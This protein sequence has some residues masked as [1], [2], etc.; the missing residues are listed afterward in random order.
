MLGFVKRLLEP[1]KWVVIQQ[2]EIRRNVDNTVV[3]LLYV[4]QDQYGR[5]KKKRICL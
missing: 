4:M 1:S 2:L 5:I 3:G